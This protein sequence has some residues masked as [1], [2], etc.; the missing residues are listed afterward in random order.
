MK[1]SKEEIIKYIR[2]NKQYIGAA[3]LLA[4]LIIAVA[5]YMRAEKGKAG[6]SSAVSGS[7]QESDDGKYKVD[8]YPEV[9]ELVNRYFAAMTSGDTEALQQ[10]ISPLE[11][12]QRNLVT[13]LS[14]YIESYNNIVCYTKKGPIDRSYMVSVCHDTKFKGIDT[15]APGLTTLYIHANPEGQLYIDNRP[16]SELE[17]EVIAYNAAFLAQDDVAALREEVEKKAQDALNADPNLQNF[18]SQTYQQIYVDY[19]AALD[20]NKK[21]Q[22]EATQP[23]APATPEQQPASEPTPAPT[24]ETPQEP[25]QPAPARQTVYATEAINIRQEPDGSAQLVGTAN[26]GFSATRIEA[27]ADGWTKIEFQGGEAYVKSEFLSDTA[28]QGSDSATT[29]TPAQGTASAGNA[30]YLEAGTQ[31]MLMDTVNVRES[32][33]EDADRL[34]VAYQGENVTVV[35]EYQEGWTKVNWNGK[36]GFIKTDFLK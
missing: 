7:S 28:P 18:V 19:Y 34:G 17:P 9:N 13:R 36:I 8:A 33:N 1:L 5:F 25:A 30:G 3:V 10:I 20:S 22:A 35:M 32:M 15:M 2:E 12:T 26:A 4:V 23:E 27:R 14:E 21:A 24:P 6:N 16:E 31:I 11:E 29:G